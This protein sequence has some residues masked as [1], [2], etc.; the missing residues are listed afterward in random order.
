M[1][2]NIPLTPAT[3]NNPVNNNH[4]LTGHVNVDNGTGAGYENAP[5]GTTITFQITSGQC[6]ICL[7]R[8]KFA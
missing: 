5:D 2:A 7:K 6:V 3:A 8:N 1:G 4:T